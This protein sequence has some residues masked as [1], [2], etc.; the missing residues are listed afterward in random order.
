M[1]TNNHNFTK[2][3]T[4]NGNIPDETII[5]REVQNNTIVWDYQVKNETIGRNT[6]EKET[7]R[8][9]IQSGHWKP[10]MI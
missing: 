2:G 8:T 1:V 4:F 3:E 9:F 6:T 7:A 10:E 5:V